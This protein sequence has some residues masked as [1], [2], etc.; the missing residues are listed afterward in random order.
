LERKKKIIVLAILGVCTVVVII[1]NVMLAKGPSGPTLSPPDI[2]RDRLLRL[3]AQVTSFVTREGRSP[4][5]LE[6]LNSPNDIVDGW[7]QPFRFT[8]TGQGKKFQCEIRST[9][10][11][12]QPDNEDDQVSTLKFGPD[13]YGGI[14]FESGNIV[15][16]QLP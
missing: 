2:T 3:T 11:D 14:G 6:E 1:W 4:A 8:S 15:P 9:G 13:P 12:T 5:S 16:S 7:K 10:A